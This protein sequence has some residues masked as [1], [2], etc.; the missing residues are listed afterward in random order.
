[1]QFQKIIFLQNWKSI[2]WPVFGVC[3]TQTLVKIY[4]RLS[5]KLVLCWTCKMLQIS[6]KRGLDLRFVV[7]AN[8]IFYLFFIYLLYLSKIQIFDSRSSQILGHYS[9]YYSTPKN[10]WISNIFQKARRGRVIRRS[11]KCWHVTARVLLLHGVGILKAL[12][13]LGKGSSRLCLGSFAMGI[14]QFTYIVMNL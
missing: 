9:T 7:E 13:D 12:L 11:L 2:F 3:S 8:T 4:N 1:M 5:Q 14:V 10:G 6:A